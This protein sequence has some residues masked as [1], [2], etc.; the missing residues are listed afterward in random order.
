MDPVLIFILALMVGLLVYF[1]WRMVTGRSSQTSTKDWLLYF[2]LAPLM[3]A[4]FFGGSYYV[5]KK[6]IPDEILFKW[7][8]IF[9]TA[10]FVFGSSVKHFWPHRKRWT[11]WAELSALILVHFIVLQRLQWQKENYWWL[12]VVVGIPE[13]FFVF[14]LLGLMFGRKARPTSEGPA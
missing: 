12:A 10:V 9:I 3:I 1:I 11:F 4:A 5:D 14:F 6:G 13:L 8:N 7:V 2:L